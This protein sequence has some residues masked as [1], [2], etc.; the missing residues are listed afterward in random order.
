MDINKV[1][2]ID[3]FLT[4][5]EC[6]KWIK[7]HKTL[8]NEAQT[9]DESTDPPTIVEILHINPTQ[10]EKLKKH[11]DQLYTKIIASDIVPKSLKLSYAQ[12]VKWNNQ[13]RLAA[14]KDIY[15]SKFA[16]V[17]YLNDN[18]QGGKTF[19]GKTKITP[20]KGRV[21]GFYGSH[22]EHGVTKVTGTRYTIPIWYKER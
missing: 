2:I 8:E 7:H 17:I 11:F 9:L 13:T 3:D 19:L 21:V 22:I 12:V 18:Y 6:K 4:D 10:D 5:T 16:I 1:V 14:H 20:K 15:G